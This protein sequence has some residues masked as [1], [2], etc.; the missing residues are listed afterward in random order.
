MSKFRQVYPTDGRMKFNGGLN[1]KYER[2]IIAENESPDCKNVRFTNEAVETRLGFKKFNTQ[3]I[4]TTFV[5]DFLG[6]RHVDDGNQTMIAGAGGSFWYASGTTFVTIPSS[7]SQFSAGLR[8]GHSE[9]ENYLFLGNG[10]Q[11]AYKYNG[12]EFTRHGIYAPTATPTVTSQSA[13]TITGGYRYK[14]TAVNSALVESDVGP[15]SVTF[16]AASATLRV[17]LE[18]FSVSYGVAARNVYRT[19]VGGAVYKYVTQVTGNV[20]TTYDDNKED[21]E[22]GANAPT[23][24]A[25]PPLYNVICYHQNRLFC[26]DTA[27][28]NYIWYSELE[29]PYSFASTN[30]IKIGDNTSDLVK[31]IEVYGDNLLVRCVNSVFLIYMA[32]NDDSNW[33]AKRLQIPFGSRSPY[34][35]F[36]FNKQIMYPAVQNGKFVGFAVV[37]GIGIQPS[38][39]FL[40][41]ETAGA[42]LASDPIEPE[43]FEVQSAEVPD[44]YAI[45]FNNLAYISVAHGSGATVNNRIWVYQYDAVFEQNGKDAWSPDTGVGANQF[46]IY[47]GN[48]YFIN[49]AGNGFVYQYEVADQYHDDVSTAI[50]SYFWTKEISVSGENATFNDF[51]YVKMLVDKAGDYDMDLGFRVDSDS[52]SGNI[53]RVDLNPGGSLWNTMIWG[54]DL[55]GG[56]DAQE[57]VKVFLGGT[58]GER[59]QFKFSNKNITDQ[60]FKVHGMR[61]YFNRKGYR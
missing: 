12:A 25:P 9:Y 16:T 28:P 13:G 31:G 33:I 47:N 10:A 11:I 43:M 19:A 52:G 32:D 7:Q 22:L 15:T 23:D 58:R 21:S 39:T 49:S 26:N 2:S 59:I 3:T 30:F 29:N 18:T 60:R 40:T 51:R 61:F 54:T 55:W 56:G 42:L 5:G 20:A 36:E 6:V 35:A 53:V 34:G 27:N 37:A 46:A 48:L 50:D 17:T 44:I 45:V 57:D 24:V 41:T 8:F 14:I 38:T 1:T 4:G